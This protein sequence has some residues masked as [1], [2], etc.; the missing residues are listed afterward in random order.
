VDVGELV[1]KREVQLEV[2][3]KG[4]VEARKRDQLLEQEMATAEKKIQLEEQQRNK[5]EKK[6]KIMEEWQKNLRLVEEQKK[7][8]KIQFEK[9]L[10]K[11]L[12]LEGGRAETVVVKKGG[13]K[14]MTSVELDAEF[15]ELNAAQMRINT[16]AAVDQVVG[17]QE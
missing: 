1:R 11:A 17:G 15:R 2:Q 3:E 8:D 5:D 9:S 7:E 6:R 10:T 12:A 13:R 14:E 16:R 4:R